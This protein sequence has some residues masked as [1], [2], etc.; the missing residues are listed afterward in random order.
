MALDTFE[1][2]ETSAVSLM[3]KKINEIEIIDYLGMG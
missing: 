1:E 3:E 2:H